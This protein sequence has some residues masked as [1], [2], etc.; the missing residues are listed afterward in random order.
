MMKR[1]MAP[2]SNQMEPW[3]GMRNQNM[4]TSTMKKVCMMEVITVDIPLPS[5]DFPGSVG[6]HQE[7]VEGAFLPF[8]GDGE[9]PDSTDPMR[10]STAIRPGTMN[11]RVMRLGAGTRRGILFQPGGGCVLARSSAP[12]LEAICWA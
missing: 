10:A 11:Q 6:S 5:R 4:A 9:G 12:K 1:R 2:E 8:P 3:K 7:L